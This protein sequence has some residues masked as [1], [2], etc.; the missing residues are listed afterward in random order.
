[1][2]C[3]ISIHQTSH[4]DIDI[5]GFDATIFSASHI[6]LVKLNENIAS[7]GAEQ[8]I[9]V[10]DEE[11]KAKL[12][13][14][15]GDVALILTILQSKGMEFDDVLLYDFFTDAH[16]QSSMKSLSILAGVKTGCF[17]AN[18]HAVSLASTL[19]SARSYPL[20]KGFS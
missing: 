3:T 11:A 4:A 17:D 7:F 19:T 2:V 13:A 20:G 6:G 9:L 14:K 15:I 18:I 8:V 12:Q 16:C 10:R 5:V 1:M